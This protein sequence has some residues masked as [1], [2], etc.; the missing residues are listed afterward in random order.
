[1]RNNRDDNKK[2]DY[3]KADNKRKKKNMTTLIFMKR[4]C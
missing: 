3:K 1:M 4:S 2:G